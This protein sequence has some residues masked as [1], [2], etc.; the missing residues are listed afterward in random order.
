MVTG[1]VP[2]SWFEAGEERTAMARLVDWENKEN[3]WLV[4]NQFEVVGKSA[5]RT[6]VL[7]FLNGMPIVVVELKGTQTG[8]LKGPSTRSKRTS[9][10]SLTCSAR[11]LSM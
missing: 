10:K 2:V 3:D 7:I 5:R 6:D 1:G 9:H 4:V 8:T 11:M